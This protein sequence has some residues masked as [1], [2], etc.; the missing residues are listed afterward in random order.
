M[1]FNFTNLIKKEV[2]NYS[3]SDAR[4]NELGT[5]KIAKETTSFIFYKFLEA[6]FK[7]NPFYLTAFK[8]TSLSFN[9]FSDAYLKEIPFYLT[10]SKTNSLSFLIYCVIKFSKS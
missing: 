8:T 5:F 2:S 6:Y 7:A 9:K 10:A 1:W 4:Q 3:S